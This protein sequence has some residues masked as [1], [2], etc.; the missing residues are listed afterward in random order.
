[1]E[2]IWRHLKQQTICTNGKIFPDEVGQ[3]YVDYEGFRDTK[4][5]TYYTESDFVMYYVDNC[6]EWKR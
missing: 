6:I 2:L 5:L 1:M 4:K 3:C